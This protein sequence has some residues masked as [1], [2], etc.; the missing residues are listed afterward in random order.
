MEGLKQRCIKLGV[1]EPE[2]AVVNNCCTV[3]NQLYNMMPDL[4]VVLDVYHFIVR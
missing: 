4:T 3:R 1:P 2:M